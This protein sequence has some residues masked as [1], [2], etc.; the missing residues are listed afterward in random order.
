MDI[1]TVFSIFRQLIILSISNNKPI[2]NKQNTQYTRAF[3]FDSS[4]NFGIHSKYLET[5]SGQVTG[6]R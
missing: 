2:T 5:A 4:T 1:Q 3:I 6:G